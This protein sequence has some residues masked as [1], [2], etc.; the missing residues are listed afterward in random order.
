MLFLTGF[1]QPDVLTPRLD[2]GDRDGLMD[3]HWICFAEPRRLKFR[4]IKAMPPQGD[5]LANLFA[6]IY[7]SH[8]QNGEVNIPYK[9]VYRLHCYK[10]YY[11]LLSL[12]L[13]VSILFIILRLFSPNRF[14]TL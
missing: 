12:L 13:T 1:I 10:E 5:D 11:Y 14:L 9:R 3:R 2:R 4:E 8:N 7:A 6:K